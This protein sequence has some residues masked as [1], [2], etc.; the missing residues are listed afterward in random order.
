MIHFSKLISLLKQDFQINQI[1]LPDDETQYYGATLFRN[2]TSLLKNVVYVCEAGKLPAQ[3]IVS[4]S[5]ALIICGMKQREIPRYDCNYVWVESPENII[6]LFSI[7]Q[8]I[9]LKDLGND[10]TLSTLLRSLITGSGIKELIKLASK[11]LN[12][13]I[14]L[15]TASYKVIAMADNG[16]SFNDPVWDDAKMYGYC[17][18]DSIARFVSEGVTERVHQSDHAFIIDE[19]LAK[20]I[21]RV[22]H[23]IV[24]KKKI[25]AYLGVFEVTHQFCSDDLK[26][27]ES[28]CEFI[29]IELKNEPISDLFTNIIYQ[30]ILVD[31]LNRS[32]TSPI[33]L[34]ERLTSAKWHP[35]LLFRCIS[36]RQRE[37][38]Q[39]NYKQDYI[40][41]QLSA[42]IRSGKVILYKQQMMVLLNYSRR[43]QMEEAVQ[44]IS[45][46][47]EPEI[48]IAGISPEFCELL[49][50]A[51]YFNLAKKAC[52]IGRTIG[53]PDSHLYF[54][55]AIPYIMMSKL[56]F[57]KIHYYFEPKYQTLIDYDQLH[58]TQ[59]EQTLNAYLNCAGNISLAAKALFIHRNTM[60]QRMERLA[61]IADIDLKDGQLLFRCQL[62]SYLRK[63]EQQ[64]WEK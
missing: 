10:M 40:F 22:L 48:M 59:F 7:I 20:T 32:L 35:D 54:E 63:W 61:Q 47:I 55:K 41:S 23:K 43:E 16:I 14:I 19:G 64:L 5:D 39:K 29:A 25:V 52:E 1:I 6:E 60:A 30:S 37:A 3:D 27:I 2:E 44:T 38:H 4:K 53:C 51:E 50:L 36:I 46:I 56:P 13:P 62:S 42:Q 26:L 34:K 57:D 21:P 18:A 28:L 24:V 17:S 9:F 11:I 31:L 8:G 33:V 12:N 49:K 15:T 45:S 58:H